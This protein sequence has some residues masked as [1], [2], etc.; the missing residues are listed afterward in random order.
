MKNLK[1][2]EKLIENI[3]QDNLR[4]R[5]DDDYLYCVV[6]NRLGISLVNMTAKDFLLSY[7]KKGFPTLESV[8]R[9]RRKAQERNEELKPDQNTQLCRK[10]CEN[11]FYSFALKY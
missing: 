5:G 7:R 9:C 11:S 4:A 1:T 3:L 10:V 8:G 2:L 6:L